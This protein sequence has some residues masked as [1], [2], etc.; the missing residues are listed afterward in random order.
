MKKIVAMIPARIGSQRLQH[1][2]LALID[3]KPLI[4]Y[5][6]NAAK[7]SKIF[8]KIF[9]NSDDSIFAK[10]AKKYKVDFYLRPKKL[11]SSNT[12]TDDVVYDFINK[13]PDTKILAWVNPIAPL[14]TS[15]DI[16]NCINFFK[17]KN[18]DSLITTTEHSLHGMFSNKPIN[19]KFDKV[20]DKT[21][22]LKKIELF[23]YSIFI[24]KCST[25]LKSYKKNKIGVMCGKFKTYPINMSR[26]IIIKNIDDLIMANL[27]IKM[28]KNSKKLFKLKYDK[29]IKK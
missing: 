6:I 5:A 10:I 16:I 26:S 1:K 21:Q 19:F 4:Y 7:K 17:R 20:F 24:W 18:I 2:N 9:I 12:K 15:K 14:Q 25:F 13:H 11:G 28:N 8:H 27:I 23:L 22:D 29:I 3:G